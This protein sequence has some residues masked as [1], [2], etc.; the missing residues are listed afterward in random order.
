MDIFTII[1][2]IGETGVLVVIAGTGGSLGTS[3]I[4]GTLLSFR[5]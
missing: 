1:K 2:T 4:A 3:G 5:V